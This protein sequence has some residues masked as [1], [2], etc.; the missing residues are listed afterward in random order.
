MLKEETIK[1]LKKEDD[2]LEKMLIITYEKFKNKKNMLGGSYLKDIC[3]ICNTKESYQDKIIYLAS[4]LIEYSKIT[5]G[6]LKAFG[7]S[8]ELLENLKNY[9]QNN[10]QVKIKKI[11]RRRNNI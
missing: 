4:K 7:F 6:E 11:Y 1:L 8:N 10:L 3:A 5:Y 2:L 9:N